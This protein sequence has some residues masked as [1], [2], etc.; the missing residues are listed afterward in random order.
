M[1]W[2]ARGIVFML[3]IMSVIV[4]TVA[5]RKLIELRRSRVATLSFSPAFSA[6]LGAADFDTAE[7]LVETHAGSHLATAFRR[8]FPSLTFHSQD[9]SLSAVEIASVARL[10]ELNSLEQIAR[11][12][13]GLGV[14]ATT[15]ATAPFVG[16]L[17]TTM[18]V[19]T[20]F[21]GMS[22]GASAGAMQQITAGIAEALITTAFGLI[23]ALP[24]VWLY[25]YFV[26]RIEYISME[27]TYVTKEFM[28]FL[29]RYEARLQHAAGP[30]PAAAVG[31]AARAS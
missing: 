31:Y 1:G 19:V 23:V 27:I 13:R 25:N 14:L 17:G 12:R 15:G 30:E 24:A 5:V 18:G 10:I 22:G 8:V 6:A 4:M 3:L 26:N 2:F 29:L 21:T 20:A 28:D 11:F 9:R 16:L 7:R